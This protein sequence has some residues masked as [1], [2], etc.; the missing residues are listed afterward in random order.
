MKL[1]TVRQFTKHTSQ[2]VRDL[3]NGYLKLNEQVAKLTEELT[4]FRKAADYYLPDVDLDDIDDEEEEELEPCEPLENQW[5]SFGDW[6]K[7]RRSVRSGERSTR[8]GL[9]TKGYP[10]GIPLFSY[11]QTYAWGYRTEKKPPPITYRGRLADIISSSVAMDTVRDLPKPFN[12]LVE[13]LWRDTE[14]DNEPSD[15]FGDGY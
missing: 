4:A 3:A 15:Y 10:L 5:L 9:P 13:T 11:A 8:R 12:Q 14:F 7:H 6:H 1:S 2:A